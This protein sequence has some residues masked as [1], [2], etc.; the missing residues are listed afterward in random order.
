M[1][2]GKGCD[3]ERHFVERVVEDKTLPK[4]SRPQVSLP[5]G[6]KGDVTTICSVGPLMR[7]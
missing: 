1:G 6:V 3:R 2:E 7:S 5:R 4:K